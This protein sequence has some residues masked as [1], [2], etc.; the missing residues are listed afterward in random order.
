MTIQ[1]RDD[2]RL[3][4]RVLRY[5]TWPHIRPQT[6]AEHSWQVARILMAITPP[7]WWGALLPHAIVHDVGEI[8][9]GDLPYPIKA[10]NPTLGQLLDRIEHTA[11]DEICDVWG[12]R[13]PLRADEWE[14][15]H[16]FAF[17]L[18][19]FI[20]MWEWGMEEA[21]LGNKFAVKVAER[22]RAVVK[23]RLSDHSQLQE[24]RDAA[25][26]YVRQRE[27]LWNNA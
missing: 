16:R 3:A 25:L 4:G 5:H 9:T 17:K 24:V 21:L 2:A 11:A 27:E 20:E 12:M 19:E 10:N 14:E 22:C 8:V 1:V 6:V 18:A 15:H 13:P 26:S 23:E 7:S